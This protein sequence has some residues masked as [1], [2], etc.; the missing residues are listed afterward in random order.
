[1]RASQ[2]YIDFLQFMTI[3]PM[4]LAIFQE[5]C[6]KVIVALLLTS[7]ALSLLIAKIVT[8]VALLG[9]SLQNRNNLPL[10][11]FQ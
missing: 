8:P 1:M 9:F 4:T 5:Q 3:D 6:H 2:I 7:N 10:K 11:I